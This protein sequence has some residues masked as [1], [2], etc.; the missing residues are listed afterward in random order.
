MKRSILY[1]DDEAACLSIFKATFGDD[2]DVCTAVTLAQ[3]SLLLSERPFDIVI[4]DQS[5]PEIKGTEF[6]RQVAEKYPAT[7]RVIL[8][9]TAH[10]G[11][12]IPQL[13]N[14][15]VQFF[16][17][18]PWTPESVQQ[19]L[20]RAYSSFDPRSRPQGRE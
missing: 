8:T 3:A 11:D 12:V 1:L 9:G 14:G 10:V 2:Y 5:M 16:I 7:R 19:V 4:S 13:I 15:V 6:L 18:K 20:D 17:V